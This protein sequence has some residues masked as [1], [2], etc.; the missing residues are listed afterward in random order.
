M[1]HSFSHSLK[2][3]HF[4]SFAQIKSIKAFQLFWLVGLLLVKREYFPI[5]RWNVM[6]NECAVVSSVAVNS[7]TKVF[8]A[9]KSNILLEIFTLQMFIRVRISIESTKPNVA[10]VLVS[11]GILLC[12]CK[13]THFWLINWTN[14]RFSVCN[15][16][17]ILWFY[18]KTSFHWAMSDFT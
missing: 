16:C 8:I 10:F 11:C 1:H 6:L 3:T 7:E 15:H 18:L 12:S 13:W 14:G 5:C 17:G 4:S 9:R 2:H